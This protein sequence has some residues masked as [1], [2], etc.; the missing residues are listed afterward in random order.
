MGGDC[1]ITSR[2]N[3]SRRD[4]S[5]GCAEER[6]K[7]RCLGKEGKKGRGLER[8]K[9]GYTRMEFRFSYYRSRNC[10]RESRGTRGKKDLTILE[11]GRK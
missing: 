8:K 6:H 5:F 2:G 3:K 7:L 4:A 1:N 11:K 9:K 10:S